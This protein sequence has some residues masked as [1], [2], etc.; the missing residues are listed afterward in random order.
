MRGS[1][2]SINYPDA[3]W[4]G[5]PMLEYPAYFES[6]KQPQY[7]LLSDRSLEINAAD[8]HYTDLCTWWFGCI[9]ALGNF[10]AFRPRN[11]RI[12]PSVPRQGQNQI[13]IGT[14]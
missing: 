7:R 11:A 1:Q 14:D 2:K 3:G 9:R 13:R 10:L 12:W 4:R 6:G 8:T 5:R